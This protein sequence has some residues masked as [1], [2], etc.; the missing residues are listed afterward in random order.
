M[1]VKKAR[2]GLSF[3][4]FQPELF[5]HKLTNLRA[6]YCYEKTFAFNFLM[7]RNKDL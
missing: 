1:L 7:V 5:A 6:P 4:H 3:A 2:S